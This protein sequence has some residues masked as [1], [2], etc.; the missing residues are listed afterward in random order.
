[1]QQQHQD[2]AGR[3]PSGAE[4]R[5]VRYD[6]RVDTVPA[7]GAVRAVARAESFLTHLNLGRFAGEP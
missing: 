6:G 4:I 7:P 5:L 3:P 2:Y 1:M